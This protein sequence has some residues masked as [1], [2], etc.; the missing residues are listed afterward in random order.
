MDITFEGN[1]YLA[2]HNGIY[3]S[4]YMNN[5]ILFTVTYK[6][7]EYARK[8]A[9]LFNDWSDN[10]KEGFIKKVIDDFGSGVGV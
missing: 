6:N 2:I 9:K 8:G 3:V 1:R 4:W 5:E 10:E 7:E